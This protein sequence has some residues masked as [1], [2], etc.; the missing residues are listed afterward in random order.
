[1]AVYYKKVIHKVYFASNSWKPI[2]NL[3]MDE[4]RLYGGFENILEVRK[5]EKLLKTF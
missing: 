3:M 4:G 5:K 1:M 2:I